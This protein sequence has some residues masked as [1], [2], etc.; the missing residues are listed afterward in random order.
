MP[1]VPGT[2]A[3]FNNCVMSS[4]SSLATN[5]GE[6]APAEVCWLG[7]IVIENFSTC[8]RKRESAKTFFE[9]LMCLAWK[10]IL[11]YMHAKE[12]ERGS[13]S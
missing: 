9:P 4:E 7:L 5:L 12:C 1:V 13:V 11:F 6:S 10:I 8:N 3:D 2:R